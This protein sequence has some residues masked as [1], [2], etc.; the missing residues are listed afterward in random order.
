MRFLFSLQ[1]PTLA[2]TSEEVAA[3]APSIAAP[4]TTKHVHVDVDNQQPEA[5]VQ[6]TGMQSAADGLKDEHCGAG[7]HDCPTILTFT[8]QVVG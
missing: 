8:W 1:V 2:R 3:E 6:E 4:V 5:E 7:E